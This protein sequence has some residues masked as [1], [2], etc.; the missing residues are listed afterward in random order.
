VFLSEFL[1]VW[2]L[3]QEALL[4]PEV[5]DVHTW[6]FEASGQKSPLNQ[7]MRLSSREPFILNLAS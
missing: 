1:D 2:D 3:V 6:K 4:Q 5:E 7:H